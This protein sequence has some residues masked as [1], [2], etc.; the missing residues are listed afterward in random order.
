MENDNLND[1]SEEELGMSYIE[2]KNLDGE[3]NL[4]FKQAPFIIADKF[5]KEE[6]YYML[7]GLL[8]CSAPNE[9]LNEFAGR[10]FENFEDKLNFSRIFFRSSLLKNKI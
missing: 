8:E 6:S 1:C 9:K 5:R 3:T 2:S 10:Y 4:K 7:D